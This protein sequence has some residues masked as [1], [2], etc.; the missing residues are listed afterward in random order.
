VGPRSYQQSSGGFFPWVMPGALLRAGAGRGLSGQRCVSLPPLRRA[1]SMRAWQRHSRRDLPC[2]IGREMNTRAQVTSGIAVCLTF[3]GA[4]AEANEHRDE[5]GHAAEQSSCDG[6]AS[7]IFDAPGS[8]RKTAAPADFDKLRADVLAQCRSAVREGHAADIVSTLERVLEIAHTSGPRSSAVTTA[9]VATCAIAPAS[10]WA[11]RWVLIGAK[12]R[13]SPLC[14]AALAT[15][16]RPEAKALVKAEIA[17]T[18]VSTAPANTGTSAWEVNP[19]IVRA[20]WDSVELRKVLPPQLR[21]AYQRRATGYFEL[22]FALCT[23]G[24]GTPSLDSDSCQQLEPRGPNVSRPDEKRN[25]VAL[26]VG[27]VVAAGAI[28]AAGVAERNSTFG[29]VTAAG[30]AGAGAGLLVGSLTFHGMQ[31]GG[32]NG[33]TENV[34]GTVYG[35]FWGTIL[36]TVVGVPTAI[37]VYNVLGDSPHARVP[38]LSVGMLAATCSV[39]TF[40][41]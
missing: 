10:D 17:Q 34:I 13:V 35:T 12:E 31:R 1:D 18:I 6:V 21:L 29:R 16:D 26:S 23:S 8:I 19:Y 4:R 15:L 11:A 5:P 30:A 14:L 2:M 38:V 24:R 28:S 40:I 36:G 39:L 41:W 3:L 27:L 32:G 9:I 37:V 20:A 33:G 22:W 25:R 7:I